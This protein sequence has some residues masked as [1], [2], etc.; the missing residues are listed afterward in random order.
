MRVMILLSL[1]INVAVLIPVSAGLMVD[2]PWAAAAYGDPSPARGI[3]LSIYAA[4]LAVSAWLLIERN[5]MLVAPLLLVQVVYKL[6]TPITVG[7]LT[8]PVVISNLLV[9]AVHL[10]TLALIL[11][12]LAGQRGRSAI[13]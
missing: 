8:N 12:N 6:T 3:L 1:L 10:V 4:I 13:A 7:S 11:R 2:A 9:A 5:A